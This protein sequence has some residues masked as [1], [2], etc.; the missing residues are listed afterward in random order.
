MYS[1]F[2]PTAITGE[3]RSGN[4]VAQPGLTTIMATSAGNGWLIRSPMLPA[5]NQLSYRH[6]RQRFVSRSCRS[7]AGSGKDGGKSLRMPSPATPSRHVGALAE[8]EASCE[9]GCLFVV[10][11]KFVSASTEMTAHPPSPRLGVAGR[12]AATESKS[13]P[14]R[15]RFELN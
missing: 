4:A 11:T 7:P 6:L 15:G 2:R 12:A 13:T 8:T 14:P 3:W 1:Q 10:K 5:Q 9:G